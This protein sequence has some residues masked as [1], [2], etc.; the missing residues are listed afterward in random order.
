ME[1]DEE[2]YDDFFFDAL[3]PGTPQTIEVRGKALHFEFHRVIPIGRVLKIQS[4]AA[5][6]SMKDGKPVVETV[7][8]AAAL[9]EMMCAVLKSWPFKRAGKPL[10]ISKETIEAMAP[11]LIT[12]LAPVVVEHFNQYQSKAL[13]GVNGPFVK[14]SADH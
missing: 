10:P 1:D 8:E 7:D 5:R 3:T 14:A 13:K 4:L 11:D 12:A 9:P 6:I 2:L